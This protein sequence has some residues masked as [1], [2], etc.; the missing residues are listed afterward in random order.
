MKTSDS[1]NALMILIPLMI[2]IGASGAFAAGSETAGLFIP[3]FLATEV[4]NFIL[5]RLFGLIL[6]E[7]ISNRPSGCGSLGDNGLCL[8]CGAIPYPNKITNPAGTGMPSG[9]TQ[10]MGVMTGV[11]TLMSKNPWVILTSWLVSGL[12]G[13]QRISSK[14]HTFLQVISGFIIGLSGAPV[15]KKI[16]QTFKK[17]Q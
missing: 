13:W 11:L 17:R 12:V 4:L 6:P 9:H 5:K 2:P 8:G 10:A 7:H 16:K 3:F 15:F 14:C 1:L